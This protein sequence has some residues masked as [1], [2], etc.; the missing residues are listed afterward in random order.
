MFKKKT[1]KKTF[2]IFGVDCKLLVLNFNRTSRL[3]RNTVSSFSICF[4]Q[5]NKKKIR[6]VVAS[7]IVYT[8]EFIN[9]ASSMWFLRNTREHQSIKGQIGKVTWGWGLPLPLRTASAWHCS[10]E[11][12][13]KRL[14]GKW[15]P[16][17]P[18]LLLLL[19][20]AIVLR[21]VRLHHYLPM[22]TRHIERK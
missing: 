21:Y 22:H 19:E 9:V 18:K 8:V 15:T 2:P 14:E 16:S 12:K 13:R 4:F 20:T 3:N 6:E 11:R 17:R 1:E 5:Q 10:S 7:Y